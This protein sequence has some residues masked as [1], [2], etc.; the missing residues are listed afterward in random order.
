MKS[1]WITDKER[2]KKE[3]DQDQFKNGKV[4]FVCTIRNV[5]NTEL[6][7]GRGNR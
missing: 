3:F 6:S 2:Q 5:N 1:I 4:L 7:N